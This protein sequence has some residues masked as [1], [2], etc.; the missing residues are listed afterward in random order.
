MSNNEMVSVLPCP[1]CGKQARYIPAD[2]VDQNGQ[3]WPFAEC[4]PCNVGAPVEFWNKRV[5]PAVPPTV[6]DPEVLGLL[7]M[8]DTF[9]T[10]ILS[11]PTPTFVWRIS[12]DRQREIKQDIE[13]VDRAHV[14]RLQAE[15]AEL[16]LQC[17]GMQMTV[18]ELQAELTAEK[19]WYDE[20]IDKVQAELDAL[21]A[22]HP[23]VG[24]AEALESCDW[25]NVPIG[26]KA[27]IASAINALKAAQGE[28]V[29]IKCWSYKMGGEQRF[30][31]S[32]PRL[33]DWGVSMAEYI[34]D[35]EP[36]CVLPA[37]PPAPVA[38]VAVV[39]PDD[40]QDQ[41]F[42][43]MTRRFELNKRDDDHMVIDDTQVGVEFA[44][45]WIAARL[46]PSL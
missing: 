12:C 35:V 5:L 42:E 20:E 18:D 29:A 39:L 30:Y 1:F 8:H 3:P 28:P 37:S 41:L 13:L 14:T 7:Q 34:T 19:K 23:A 24:I 15:N 36:L 6:V 9:P 38:P 31:P 25:S 33:H 27:I 4:N 22:A 32:D 16:R 43:E 11:R 26:N 10:S 46:N 2:Y 44:S 40:W 17:G 45:D 21:K